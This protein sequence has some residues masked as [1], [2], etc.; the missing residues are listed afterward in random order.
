LRKEN[1]MAKLY[2]ATMYI[3]DVNECYNNLEEILNEA[4]CGADDITKI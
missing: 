2:K 1:I 3:L 4:E